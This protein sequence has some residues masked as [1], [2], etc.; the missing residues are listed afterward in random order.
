MMMAR[1][2][3]DRSGLDVSLHMSASSSPR[4][5]ETCCTFMARLAV[6]GIRVWV[7]RGIE[8]LPHRG[9]DFSHRL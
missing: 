9:L 4:F 2:F 8:R 5:P 6:H 7:S 1:E 3:L